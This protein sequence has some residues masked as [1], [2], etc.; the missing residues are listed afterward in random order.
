MHQE[1][2]LSWL[3]AAF[4]RDG[5]ICGEEIL[6]PVY[7]ALR[8]EKPLLITGAPG[9]GKTEVAKVLSRVLDTELIRLQCYE[10]LDE[11]KALYEWNYQKQLLMIELSRQ[12]CARGEEQPD[13]FSE[14][15][16]LERPLLKALRHP[17]RPVL[18]IDE[19]DKS[20]QEFEAFLF[21][22]LSDFQVSIPELGTIKAR[23]VPVVVLTSNGDRELSDGLKR[24]CLFLYIDYPDVDK[25]TRI[26]R[27]KVPE[28]GEVLARQVAAA[29]N[30]IRADL[31]LRKKPAIAETIDWA[32]ALVLMEARALEPNLLRRTLNL[33]FKDQEDVETFNRELGVEELCR[34]VINGA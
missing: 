13:L 18:L 3:T 28:A 26:I 17:R 22:V 27:T 15:Y 14:E 34:Q 29:V 1:I 2:T 16:L 33:L 9:V 32:R 8:L 4:A 31:D 11:N 30:R 20:D 19:I 6:I 5:Y 7:L 25:E 10:G 23:Q 12:G 21:E 24:R